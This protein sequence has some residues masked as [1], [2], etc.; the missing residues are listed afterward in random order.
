M[1]CLVTAYSQRKTSWGWGLGS[2][3]PHDYSMHK[4]SLFTFFA[5]FLIVVNVHLKQALVHL[6]SGSNLNEEM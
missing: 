2:V 6:F 1:F 3:F 5:S 4:S